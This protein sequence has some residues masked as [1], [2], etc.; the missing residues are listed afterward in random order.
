MLILILQSYISTAPKKET[1]GL[2]PQRPLLVIEQ[3]PS[4]RFAKLSLISLDQ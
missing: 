4:E 3:E 2:D 1:K